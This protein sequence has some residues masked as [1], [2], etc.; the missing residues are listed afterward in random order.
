MQLY[1]KKD[2]SYISDGAH[3]RYTLNYLYVLKSVKENWAV[4]AF[5]YAIIG[6]VINTQTSAFTNVQVTPL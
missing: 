5:I 4:Y 1:A 2:T 6:V 3:E